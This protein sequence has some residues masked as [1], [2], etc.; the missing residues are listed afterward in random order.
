MV[1][2]RKSCVNERTNLKVQPYHH[3]HIVV[4]DQRDLI[5]LQYCCLEG[6]E[7]MTPQLNESVLTCNKNHVMAATR[8]T[9]LLITVAI[10]VR[11][12]I[13]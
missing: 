6:G 2:I 10:A 11:P 4:G 3:H 5:Q 12:A 9:I 1:Q 7:L 8:I 13:L